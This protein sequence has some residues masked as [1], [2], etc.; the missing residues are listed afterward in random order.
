MT[1]VAACISRHGAAIGADLRLTT[2][3]TPWRRNVIKLVLW[4]AYDGIAVTGFTGSAYLPKPSS[5]G[6]LIPTDEWLAHQIHG[7]QPNRFLIPTIHSLVQLIKNAPKQ[8]HFGISTVGTRYDRRGRAWPFNVCWDSTSSQFDGHC[9]RS[10]R[11]EISLIGD[12]GGREDARRTESVL[13]QYPTMARAI[14][15]AIK[16]RSTETKLVGSDS[17]TVTIN[18][19]RKVLIELWSDEDWRSPPLKIGNTPK[20]SSYFPWIVGLND[21]TPAAVSNGNLTICSDRWEIF[22]P[23]SPRTSPGEWRT[24][25]EIA[26]APYP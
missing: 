21:I 14:A 15:E 18:P 12:V 11:S 26:R 2:S 5:S 6:K 1:L 10:Y 22:S 24:W 25:G 3:G 9:R 20:V 17:V 23:S 16:H 13:Y 7:M 4:I 8:G 19:D